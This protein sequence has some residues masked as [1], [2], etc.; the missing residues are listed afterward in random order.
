MLIVHAY[1]RSSRYANRIMSCFC[2]PD[3]WVDGLNRPIAKHYNSCSMSTVTFISVCN[4]YA[5]VS[6]DNCT[7]LC[8][9]V[10]SHHCINYYNTTINFMIA[11]EVLVLYCKKIIGLYIYLI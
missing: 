5:T 4:R 3:C 10:M 6:Y 1:Y 7:G 11:N 2:V 8:K 9:L